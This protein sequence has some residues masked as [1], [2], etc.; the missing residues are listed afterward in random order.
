MSALDD[1]MLAQYG[2]THLSDGTE[3]GNTLQA[4][5]DALLN[6][7]VQQV[8][9]ID[10]AKADGVKRLYLPTDGDWVEEARELIA[11]AARAR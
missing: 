7:V 4:R 8:Q 5:H 10:N 3:I 11:R 6:L 2:V 1:V 9:R